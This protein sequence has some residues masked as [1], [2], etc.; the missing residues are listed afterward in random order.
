MELRMLTR[1][2]AES[3]RG[4][5]LAALKECPSAFTADYEVNRQRPLAHFA[6]QIQSLPDNFVLGAFQNRT[7][8]GMAI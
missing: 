6:A 7:L 4:L 1:D 8:A 5:R 3:F 2:D